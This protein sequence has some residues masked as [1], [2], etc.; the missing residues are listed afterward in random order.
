MSSPS[1]HLQPKSSSSSGSLTPRS[2]SESTSSS[3]SFDIVRCSRCQRS[4]SIENASSPAP[5]VVQFGMNSYYC[6]RCASMVGF[7]RWNHKLKCWNWFRPAGCTGFVQWFDGL[8]F[9]LS[10]HVVLFD[11]PQKSISNDDLFW[12]GF[13]EHERI[14]SYGEWESG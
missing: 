9:R 4:L 6:S 2:S 5:G 7:N 3:V 1:I 8:L 10:K 12:M 14:W 11:M 13:R